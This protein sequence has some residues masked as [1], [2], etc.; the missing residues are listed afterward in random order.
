MSEAAPASVDINAVL[1]SEIK[2]S[3]GLPWPRLA[4]IE[5]VQKLIDFCERHA[6]QES[7]SGEA[8]D[9]LSRYL[10]T[11]LDQ[12]RIHRA[13]D[14]EY[15]K[16]NG[17]IVSIPGL[18]YHAKSGRYTLKREDTEKRTVRKKK[19]SPRDTTKSSDNT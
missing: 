13:R 14:V 8:R 11:A 17:V 10:R 19:K 15:D 1:E 16:E 2:A 5:R 4:K 7:L 12:R 3:S 6:K 9:S 18:K